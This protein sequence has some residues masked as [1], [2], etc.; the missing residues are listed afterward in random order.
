MLTCAC[1]LPVKSLTATLAVVAAELPVPSATVKVTV[2]LPDE[3]N[4]CCVLTPVA[5][6]PSPKSQLYAVIPLAA[7]VVDRDPSNWKLLIAA[8]A[9][10]PGA[11]MPI[12]GTITLAVG[13]GGLFDLLHETETA[14]DNDRVTAR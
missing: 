6:V 11:T 2:L 1:Q 9:S 3:S 12:D 14:A 5:R 10:T 13:G 7:L 8:I 4:T